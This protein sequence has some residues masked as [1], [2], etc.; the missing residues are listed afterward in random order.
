MSTTPIYKFPRRCTL[1]RTGM[2]AGFV[3]EEPM[4]SNIGED[5]HLY[6]LTQDGAESLCQM[7]YGES[8]LELAE[9]DLAYYTE[10]DAEDPAEQLYISPNPDGS[11][12][13]SSQLYN[14]HLT[15]Q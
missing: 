13:I 8:Y 9:S 7:L 14:K 1:T 15:L 4:L 3:I 11:N 6:A 2:H 10:W 5:G 12:A